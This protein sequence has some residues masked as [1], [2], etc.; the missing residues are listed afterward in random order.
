MRAAGGLAT[1]QGRRAL[2]LLEK[3]MLARHVSPGGAADLLAAALFLDRLPASAPAVS[4]TE[5]ADQ[6]TEHGAS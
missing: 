2:R 1:P 4:D 5:S 3:D 6:E